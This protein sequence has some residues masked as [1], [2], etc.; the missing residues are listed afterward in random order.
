MCAVIPVLSG[1]AKA[2]IQRPSTLTG[3]VKSFHLT[4]LS[5]ARPATR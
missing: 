1:G 3:N 5:R 2:P 4:T